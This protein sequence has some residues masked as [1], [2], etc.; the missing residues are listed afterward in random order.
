MSMSVDGEVK[1]FNLPDDD[2]HHHRS[3]G[4]VFPSPNGSR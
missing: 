1:E 2:I 3:R 4:V